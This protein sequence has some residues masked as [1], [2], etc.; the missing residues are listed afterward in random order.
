MNVT[1]FII[2]SYDSISL[3]E[4]DRVKLMN[5]VDT[6]FVCS[7]DLIPL[8]LLENNQNYKVLEVNDQR[9]M[10]YKTV[11]FD[12]P[13]FKM[14]VDHQNGK[15]NRYKIRQREY[16]VSGVNYL[17]I[18]FKNNKGRTIKSRISS[19]NNQ[20]AIQN[21]AQNFVKENTPFNPSE[22]E[23]KLWNNFKRITLV[24][25]SERITIDFALC[26]NNG[27][28][29]TIEYFDLAIVEVKQESQNFKSSIMQSLKKQGIRPNGF[30]K[31][32]VG[33]CSI[34]NH[35]KYNGFKSKFLTI[36]KISA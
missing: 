3:A 4:T 23:P 1:E 19:Q 20:F 26:F 28:D 15:L 21:G 33:A 31:Y 29:R 36:N 6:K 7:F 30:S 35:L 9:I 13:D 32:C 5:R 18:K 2:K 25:D 10:P 22:L 12:T 34:Y 8:I 27:D 11:Y 17:E 16:L 24:A 14:Y